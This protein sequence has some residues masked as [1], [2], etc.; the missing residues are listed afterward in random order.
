[1]SQLPL[2]LQQ[3]IDQLRQLSQKNILS[4]WQLVNQEEE[5][6]GLL[7]PTLL[8]GGKPV[9][10]NAKNQIIWPKG[11][12]II[13]LYQS[14][15]IPETLDGYS[16]AGLS[17]KL[18]LTWWAENVQIFVNGKL[19]QSGDLFDSSPRVLI[20][21]ESKIGES[22][23]LA[24]RLVSPGHDQGA[25]M[26]SLLI[27][28]STDSAKIEPGFI[29][30]A[31]EVAAKICCRLH[32]Q[33][34]EKLN[35]ALEQ[36]NWEAFS[37]AESFNLSLLSCYQALANLS[38]TKKLHLFLLGHAHLDLAWLWPTSE[39]WQV[40]QNTFESA[41]NLSQDFPYLTFC[42]TT[43]AL[44]EWIE[45]HRPDLFSK[46]QTQVK[47][48]NWEIVGG[49]W[50]EPELNVIGGESIARQI[51]Y[52]QRYFK[53][54]FGH[55]SAIAW[56]PDT[57]GFCATL[58]QFLRQG[59]IQYFV[60]QKLRWNDSTQFPHGFFQWQ[61]PDGT[62]ILS[63]MSAPI[64]EGFDPL[65]ITQYALD[66][67]QQTGSDSAFWLLGVGDH[68]GGPTRD[69]LEIADRWQKSP[70]F[71]NV[72]FVKAGDY[73]KGL[74]SELNPQTL[75][76]WQDELY[77]EFH[78]GCY[79]THADQ[80]RLNRQ[81]EI[82]LYQVEVLSC[83]TAVLAEKAYPQVEIEKL[84]K[85][86]LFNQFHDILPG[87]SIPEV[88]HEANLR[89]QQVL[90]QGQQLREEALDTIA[91][92]LTL[93]PF[94]HPQALPLL[95][96]NP[97]PWERS[98]VLSVQLPETHSWQILTLQGI[99]LSSFWGEDGKTKFVVEGVPG[100]G[101]TVVWAVPAEAESIETALIASE[102]GEKKIQKEQHTS[103]NVQQKG[104][105]CQINSLDPKDW[106]LDN[107]LLR[108]EINP[109]TG[110]IAQC[111][112]YSMQQDILTKP[113]GNQLQFFQDQGQYWDAWNIDP[114]Y[115]DYPLSPAQLIDIKWLECS[116]VRQAIQTT[117]K[118]NQS[119]F[120]QTYEL[121]AQS[122]YLAIHTQVDWQEK[123]TLVKAAFP[124]TIQSN[125]ATYEIP[126][127][128]IARP[129]HPQTPQEKA[130]WEVPALSWADLSDGNGGVSLIN[131]CK[132]G[133]D[134][135][136]SQL[137]LT[138]LR[139]PQW[140]HENADM[141]RHEFSYALYPHGGSWQKAATPRQSAEFNQPIAV[142]ILSTLPKTSQLPAQFK[143]LQL[144]SVNLMITALKKAEEGED[145]ILRCYESGGEEASVHVTSEGQW[146]LHPSLDLLETPQTTDTSL[147]LTPWQLATFKA[148]F[149]RKSKDE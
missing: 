126:C 18:A 72:Q 30:D 24:L 104:D 2:R 115:P 144:D 132:Y 84:W 65:K 63:F 123:H 131:N 146:H 67:Q 35:S 51:L 39:T 143:F 13:W 100:M 71:P 8:S 134:C 64:G 138:L 9:E 129:T 88:F 114:N 103:R 135:Q 137:R 47:T 98:Q 118:F 19:V 102:E 95:L 58:P 37:Q 43:P 94:P 73:L 36:I 20:T 141:G 87:T 82:L 79:T 77:L 4:Q 32:P 1:M 38:I 78:R 57:F 140:P 3:S 59:Q 69:M 42:H 21:P 106:I 22:F 107:H 52:G 127:G 23:H 12:Q 142:K 133:Y 111:F 49:M 7:N 75:P 113:Q 70:V 68:G 48:G 76:V 16:M 62:Q 66:W 83:L 121:T 31:V 81:C 109:E 10:L 124:L 101:Y 80:K 5:F 125:F 91:S 117:L 11:K 56:L 128:A 120:W 74:E 97:L 29:A 17:L 148:T 45:E 108:V 93:P 147:T 61:A 28:E 27:Y 14:L 145:F 33:N 54:K 116:P 55:Y 110:E 46:I 99:E 89:W 90:E 34:L 130:K 53:E 15:V 6:S 122:P 96:W 139:S 136:G 26:R 40:A 92:R 50:V 112:D 149:Q 60:T 85:Q 105:F 41:L 119:T 44:Y 86:V 25:L